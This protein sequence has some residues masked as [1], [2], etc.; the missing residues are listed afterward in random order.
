[1]PCSHALVALHLDISRPTENHRETESHR[2][3]R[4]PLLLRRSLWAN[5]H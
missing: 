1:M 4:G 3:L 2:A 5:Q